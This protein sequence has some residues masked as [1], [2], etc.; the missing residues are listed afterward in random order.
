M[1]EREANIDLLFR[2][3]LKDY[4]VLPPQEVWDGIH[5]SIKVRTGSYRLLRAAA[6]VT[7]LVSLGFLAYLLSG[8]NTPVTEYPVLTMNVESMTPLF[9][10][11]AANPETGVTAVT[12]A[13][14]IPPES[15]SPEIQDPSLPSVTE[16]AFL[17]EKKTDVAELSM[18]NLKYSLKH[19]QINST[20]ATAQKKTFDIV[21]P[22]PEYIPATSPNTNSKRWSIGAIAA[23]TYYS[24]LSSGKSEVSRQLAS[25]EE[26]LM[27]Y[28]GGVALA[29][30]MNKRLSIQS[31]LYYSSLG[32]EVSGI[33]SY[34]GFQ[35]H[36]YTKADHNFEVNTTS[37]PIIANNPDVFLASTGQVE[38][39]STTYTRDVFDP[40]KVNLQ[41]INNSLFQNFSYL[42]LPVILRYKLIDKA[43]DFNLIGG[44]SYNL[45]VKN[46]VYAT[47]EGG[48]KYEIGE[49]RGLNP[50]TLSSSIGMGMEYSFANN[51]SLNLEPTFRYYLNPFDPSAISDN[52]PYTFGIFT[53]ISYKF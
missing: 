4:E 14:V 48:T 26:A 35:R 29:Y 41:Y 53:G 8:D 32:Q 6:V 43:L 28:T 36:V 51:L 34:A 50:L 21:L 13:E 19:G 18:A 5:P 30:K 22:E 7:V 44:I 45:L 20:V 1:D 3:G 33:S 31:G 47:T 11:P 24:T 27:S 40:E 12:V 10:P 46:S 17:S 39:I 49:T 2:N 38:R 25:S 42:E 15:Y 23:P 52:H 16:T 9:A 37:G